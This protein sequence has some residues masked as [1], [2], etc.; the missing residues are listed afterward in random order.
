MKGKEG[1][2]EG[3]E[4]RGEGREGGGKRRGP[5]LSNTF[6]GHWCHCH[7]KLISVVKMWW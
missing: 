1:G 5:P 4:R 2:G 6:R 3:K 7:L